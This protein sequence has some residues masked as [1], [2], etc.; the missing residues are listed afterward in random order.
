MPRDPSEPTDL[1][2]LSDDEFARLDSMSRRPDDPGDTLDRSARA[3]RVCGSSLGWVTASMSPAD[4]LDVV[5]FR[6]RTLNLSRT[7][8]SFLHGAPARP[9]DACEIVAMDASGVKR[10]LTSRVVRCRVLE[11]RVHEVGVRFDDAVRIDD[12]V[13]QATMRRAG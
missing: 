11:G 4:G 12:L 3:I 6:V 1:L 10:R 2:R 9:G 7:G 8:M 5:P 13:S